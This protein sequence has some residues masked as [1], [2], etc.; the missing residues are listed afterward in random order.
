MDARR[1][2]GLRY[3]PL[4]SWWARLKGK[5]GG[6]P[7]EGAPA[8]QPAAQ[9][10]A[11]WLAPTDNPFGVPVLDL[12]SVT[13]KLLSTTQDP[14]LAARA[15]SWGDSI[16]DEL[17]DSELLGVAPRRCTLRYPA[18]PL[19]TDGLV[20]S[21][22]EM[23]H[24]WVLA[25]RGDRVLLAR[26]WTGKVLAV[27]HATREPEALVLDELRLHAESGLDVFGDPIATF[28]WL[29]RTSALGQSL[30]LPIDEDGARLLENAPLTVFGTHGHLAR[31][32]ARSWAPPPPARPVRA[33]GA[34]VRAVR[35]GNLE[36]LRALAAA[37]APLDAQ[38]PVGGLRP[39]HGAVIKR[40]RTLVELL[41]DLGADPNLGDD[42][43]LVPLGLA[44]VHRGDV[45]LLD[46]L[47]ERGA[48]TDAVNIDGFGL[49]H[50]VAETDRADLLPWMLAH[51]VPLETRTRHGHTP[52]HIACALGH[53][54][55][56]EA[57][58]KAG[59]DPAA[60]ASGRDALQI[61]I[62]EKQPAVIALL[63]RPAE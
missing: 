8:A 27:A 55:T 41:L 23:E 17:D 60:L 47:R 58:L 42:R 50:A 56:A 2:Q 24:K 15:V 22:R 5:L 31:C 4:V 37:G 16:G 36:S 29:L 63:R 12:F 54:A 25:L 46:L 40:H 62:D 20:F 21:P 13:G 34:V 53:V 35:R 11:R 48:R 33:D 32:A 44:I 10:R 7:S 51:G 30:P 39:L 14:A 19:L 45:T 6:T 43:A 3:H 18:D 28:D 9:P 26:S 52:L 38:G 49:L 61:A 1:W 59:A 57:L